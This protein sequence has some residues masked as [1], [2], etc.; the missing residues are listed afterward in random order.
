MSFGLAIEAQRG[1]LYR[2]ALRLTHNRDDAEDLVQETMCKAIRHEHQFKPGT[3][4]IGWL[5]T[6][7]RNER[8]DSRRIRRANTVVED[9][10]GL[11]TNAMVSSD[12][13]AAAY[14]ARDALARLAGLP[15]THR[16][17]MVMTA[18][19]MS[20]HDVAVMEGV[21]DGTIKSRVHRGRAMLAEMIEGTP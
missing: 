17:A 7:M 5:N 8:F 6:I 2:Y 15:A 4:L 3:N 19:G 11:R 13:V 21:P 12:D 14:E 10:D 20:T 1:T 18:E 16:R 9:A